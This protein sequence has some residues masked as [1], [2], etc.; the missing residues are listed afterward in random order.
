VRLTTELSASGLDGRE[1]GF[2]INVDD[3]AVVVAVDVGAGVAAVITSQLQFCA[4][5]IWSVD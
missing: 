4:D 2:D 1:G 3:G 5:A